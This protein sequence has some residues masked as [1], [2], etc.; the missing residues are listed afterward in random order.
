MEPAAGRRH[1]LH[2][3]ELRQHRRPRRDHLAARRLRRAAAAAA[4]Y[5]AGRRGAAMAEPGSWRSLADDERRLQ[6]LRRAPAASRPA[7]PARSS[8]PSS[9]SSTSS[10]T[11]AT[12]AA[13]A[14]RLPLRRDRGERTDDGRAWKCTLCY[15][16]QKDGLEPACAK[17]C[18]TES[19]QFGEV[20]EL[21]ARAARAGGAL[22]ARG[23]TDA[24]LYGASA[25]SQPG[26][27]PQ[28]LLSAGGSARGL[29]PAARSLR[30]DQARRPGLAGD[31][32]RRR[33]DGPRRA[34]QRP[35]RRPGMSGA[36]DPDDGRHIEPGPGGAR[37]GGGRPGRAA[38]RRAGSAGS[39]RRPPGGGREPDLLR[40][41]GHQGAGLEG[42]HRRVLLRR[43]R[44]RGVRDPRGRGPG[45]G[46]AS[47]ARP[48]A[49]A[50][51]GWPPAGRR[52]APSC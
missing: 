31:G 13:T 4:G 27:R 8:A 50:A 25:E 26:R 14:S 28:R 24:Y 21:R 7:R 17:A 29:Q 36:G 2:R 40:P 39:G 32:R 41:A 48:G 6:A 38:P 37:R 11:S 34:G 30:A 44:D 23:V 9:A 46:R 18:P 47:P 52:S 49:G 16:R 5:G 42:D 22:H 15:D 51:G 20:E 19:I 10:R 35:H 43:R 33:H 1:E 45:G 12:A 3:D